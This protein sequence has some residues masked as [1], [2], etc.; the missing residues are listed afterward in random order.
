MRPEGVS[1]YIKRSLDLLQVDYVDLYLVHTPFAFKDIEGEL[2]PFSPDGKINMDVNTDHIA[3][4]KVT[5]ALFLGCIFRGNN[6]SS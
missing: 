6:F 2:H 5:E 3:I 4:W 1:K